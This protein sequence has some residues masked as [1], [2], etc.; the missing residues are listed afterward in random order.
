MP[1]LP[2]DF[3]VLGV[4]TSVRNT[5]LAVVSMTGNRMY[6]LFHTTVHVPSARPL[7]GCLLA[8]REAVEKAIADYAP[9]AVAVEGIFCGKFVKTAVLLGHARGVVLATAAAA[10]LPVYEYE[11]T[12]VKQAVVGTG[13]A[14]KHQMQAMMQALLRLPEL[15]PEDEGDALAIALCH[16]HNMGSFQLNPP[17]TL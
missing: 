8:I 17:R 11:P 15:P 13:T 5:G 10:G 6:A 9:A 14:V 4:D 7:T 3:R 1:D 12:R 2:P 16:L